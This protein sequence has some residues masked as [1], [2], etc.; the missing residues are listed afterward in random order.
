MVSNW[1]I[2]L[3]VG[4]Q[5][6]KRQMKTEK[7]EECLHVIGY[8][9]N[10]DESAINKLLRADSD[11]RKNYVIPFGKEL[12]H[13]LLSKDTLRAKQDLI[14]FYIFEFYGLQG[15][16][17]RYSKIL[18]TGSLSNYA[19]TKYEHKNDKGVKRKL[20]KFEN[21]TV[22]SNI[23]FDVLFTE[24]QLCCIKYNID[25][26]EICHQLNF[27][28]IFFDSGITL[29]YKEKEQ[30]NKL[31]QRQIALIHAYKNDPITRDNGPEIAKI[32]G[33]T[34]KT[35]GEKLYQL[36]NEYYNPVDRKGDEGSK[37]KNQSKVKLIQSII[38]HLP[39]VNQQRAK[40]EKENLIIMTN[41]NYD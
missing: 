19:P 20:D 12:N 13:N 34:S 8:W 31:S 28:T 16:Y 29:F 30:N 11:I 15:F 32:N 23:L 18:T 41:A 14:R 4:G 3:A 7:L 38:E 17:K 6:S 27:S 2:K 9:L 26:Y 25:F 39:I 22:N 24:I 35:S 10:E 1:Q 33:Y 40:D 5:N 37:R 21:Y 36:F